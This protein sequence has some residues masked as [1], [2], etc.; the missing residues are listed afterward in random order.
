MKLG[1]QLSLL[2]LAAV[3]FLAPCDAY[4]QRHEVGLTLG[5]L[6]G[7]KSPLQVGSGLAFQ[8]NYAYLFLQRKALALGVEAH[9][10]ASPLQHIDAADRGATRDFSSLYVVP[11]LRVKFRPSSRISPY[12]AA[13]AGYALFEQSLNRLDGAAN[14]APRLTNRGVIA[15]GGGVDVRVWRFLSARWEIREFYSGNPSFNTLVSGSGFNNLAVG[16]GLVLR[17]GSPE[18]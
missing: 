9:M 14:A 18:N 2:A 15:F 7:S 1:K 4:A 16:G 6:N 17:L 5:A 8:A 10:L 12:A 13:G 3:A 11:G